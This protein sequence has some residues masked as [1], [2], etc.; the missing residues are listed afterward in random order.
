MLKKIIIEGIRDFIEGIKNY[1]I[2]ITLAT[3]DIKSRYR[4]SFLG[5]VWITINMSIVILTL[6][7]IYSLILKQNSDDYIPNLTMGFIFWGLISN[8]ITES[9]NSFRSMENIIKQI[10]MPFSIFLF[11]NIYRN[12]I[13]FAH[14]SII[15]IPIFFIY[16]DQFSITINTLFFIPTIILVMLNLLWMTTLIAII[17]TRYSDMTQLVGNAMQIIFFLTPIIWT[18]DLLF[19]HP[20]ILKFNIFYHMIEALR[21]SLFGR[22]MD[23]A[24]IV[25]LLIFLCIG[26]II[27]LYVFSRVKKS[28]CFWV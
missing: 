14:N 28:I 23:I 20:L 13:V 24:G 11:K 19:N 9:C 4:R 7:P 2:W 22:H 17:C 10:S 18:K 8:S 5:P 15:L 21:L 16:N 12:L 6:G 3:Q 26:T 1:P 27:S 25:I